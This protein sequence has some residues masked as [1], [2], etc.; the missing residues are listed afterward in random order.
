M[1]HKMS[2]TK[3][4]ET[5]LAIHCLLLPSLKPSHGLREK[6]RRSSGSE[7]ACKL[8]SVQSG[9]LKGCVG[10]FVDA[11]Q[12][13]QF[14]FYPHFF[15]KSIP[16]HTRAKPD[17]LSYFLP[18]VFFFFLS[19]IVCRGFFNAMQS[20]LAKGSPLL[21]VAK[22][23]ERMVRDKPEKD[24]SPP[25]L[26]CLPELSRLCAQRARCTSRAEAHERLSKCQT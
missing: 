1:L 14:I 13:A 26:R 21:R 8:S 23:S 6:P 24:N 5:V 2:S 7:T 11:G 17:K 19:L 3:P 16:S 4:R 10:Y 15:V 12:L 25:A 9:G 18:L 22:Q 20:A